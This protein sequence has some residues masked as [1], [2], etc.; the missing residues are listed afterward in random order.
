M[1]L[2]D[3]DMMCVQAGVRMFLIQD[4]LQKYLPCL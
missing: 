2:A 3:V 4:L 1:N